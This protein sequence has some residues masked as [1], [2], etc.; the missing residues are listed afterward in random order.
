MLLIQHMQPAFK[1]DA[2]YHIYT[3]ANGNESLFRTAENYNYFLQRYGYHI[4]PIAE[5]YA[6]CL[7]PNHIHLM[8]GIRSK[9]EVLKYICNKKEPPL[10]FHEFE[11]IGG[12]SKIISRQ[13]SHLFNGYTQA[14][15]KRHGRKGSLFMPNFKR[16]LVV[17]DL[18]FSRLIAYIHNNPVHHG[19]VRDLF[20]WPH[21]S[22]HAYLHEKSTKLNRKFLEA[23]F[24]DK[25]A[26]LEFHHSLSTE[27]A[28]EF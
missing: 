15:N 7:M 17:N 5:T 28:L 14:F 24:G 18:Y 16:K 22:I 6:Y 23:W 25:A 21:S 12:F 9:D 20:D 13:F 1:P 26:L 3:H 8:I 10:A 19:F 11:T 2:I 4:Y 27:K